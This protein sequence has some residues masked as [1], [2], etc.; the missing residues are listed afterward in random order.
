MRP[1]WDEYFMQQCDLIATRATCDR[2]KVGTIIVKNNRMI[3][4]GYNGSLPGL[5]HCDN[6]G[7]CM[8]NGHCITTVH[9][10]INSILDAAKRGV[11]V[12]GAIL[13]C[14]TMP[15]WNCFKAIVSAGI[16]E[17]VFH[18]EYRA[19]QKDKIIETA[20]LIPGFTLRQYIPESNIKPVKRIRDTSKTAPKIDASEIA[21][22]L[23]AELVDASQLPKNIPRKKKK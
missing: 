22:A 14:N 8:E 15:C 4:T 7:H 9:S 17:I 3:S 1:S 20:L 5:P 10:E 19:E 11:S 21:K 16:I 12:D 18:D 23:G 2:K 6:V 13:Y